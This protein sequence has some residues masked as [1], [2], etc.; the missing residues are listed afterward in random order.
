MNTSELTDP[1]IMIEKIFAVYEP[2]KKLL[3]DA[4]WEDQELEDSI[5]DALGI[6]A[7]A[8]IRANR[9]RIQFID[10]TELFLTRRTRSSIPEE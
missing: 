9:P 8:Q 6:A 2:I 4:G 3:K 1:K 5:L 10:R 7:N